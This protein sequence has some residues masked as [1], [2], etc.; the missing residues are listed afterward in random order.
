MREIGPIVQ[1]QVQRSALK[2]G[3]KPDRTYSP[4]PLLPVE[5]LWV[6]PAGVLGGAAD[7]SWLVDVHHRDHPASRNGD[8]GNGVSVGFTAHYDRMRERFGER[9]TPGCAGENLIAHA[10]GVVS[11]DDLRHGLAVRGPDGAERLRLRVLEVARP[12]RPFTGWA[13]GH[14]V[15]SDVLKESLQFLDGGMRGFYCVAEGS[16]EIA[17]GDRLFAL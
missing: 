15:E 6:T 14:R 1:L 8:G 9:I 5:R 11:Y 13:L 7:G 3:A 16:A 10:P 4:A 17:V 2:T 12:C